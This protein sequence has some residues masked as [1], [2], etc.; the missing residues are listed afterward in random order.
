MTSQRV[1]SRVFK[2][3]NTWRQQAKHCF[4]V[5]LAKRLADCSENTV[6]KGL[7]QLHINIAVDSDDVKISI[8]CACR[9]LFL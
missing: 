3:T 7:L 2:F 8:D 1:D 5:Q 9:V 6:V 4:G